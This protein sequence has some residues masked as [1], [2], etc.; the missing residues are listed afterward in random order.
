[1]AAVAAVAAVAVAVAVAAAV[2]AKAVAVAK[3]M[4][5]PY[6]YQVSSLSLR[7]PSRPLPWSNPCPPRQALLPW[8]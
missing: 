3:S 1:M 8:S 5:N 7:P 4:A 6:S 2:A